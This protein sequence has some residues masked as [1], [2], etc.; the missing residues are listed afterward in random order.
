LF[1]GKAEAGTTKRRY[2]RVSRG[3][4]PLEVW[5]DENGNV[6]QRGNFGSLF[7]PKCGGY[8]FLESMRL[9]N[10]V[11]GNTSCQW[12]HTKCMKCGFA[13]HPHTVEIKCVAVDENEEIAFAEKCA[14][15]RDG[16]ELQ[17]EYRG[18]SLPPTT[19]WK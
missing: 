18:K 1:C 10:T 12:S 2:R 16:Y 5:E 7:C 6:V 11:T 13:Y 4:A 17:S 8:V 15:G 3:S 14:H 9:H 19:V